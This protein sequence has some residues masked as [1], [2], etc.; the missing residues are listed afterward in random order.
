[1]SDPNSTTWEL[2]H[3]RFGRRVTMTREGND[4]K[5]EIHPCSQRDEGERIWHLSRNLLI[6]AGKIA[7]QQR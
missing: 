1:M 6:E 2:G 4:Y 3:D 7:E 5:V